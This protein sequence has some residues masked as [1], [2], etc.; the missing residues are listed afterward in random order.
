M[1]SRCAVY[2]LRRYFDDPRYEGFGPVIR[3]SMP[4][5]YPDH[6]TTRNWRIR[7]IS[8][9]WEPVAVA[10]RVRKDNDYPC[11][12]NCP[13]FSRRAVDALRDYL[14]P[15]GEILPLKSAVGEYYA[16]NT[17]TI[18]DSLDVKKSRVRWSVEPITAYR[19]EHFKFFPDKLA[20]HT[21]FLIPEMP[22]DPLVTSEFVARAHL[23]GLNG[24]HFVKVW[25]LPENVLWWDL[26][27]QEARIHKQ[28]GLRTGQTIKGNT[29]MVQLFLG[30]QVA[31]P[32]ERKAVETVMNDI[33]VVLYSKTTD[34]TLIG[35][36]EGHDYGVPGECR[37]FI[38]C[39]DA[40]A[41][42]EKLKPW[43]NQLKW[44]SANTVQQRTSMESPNG[45]R[46]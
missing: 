17:T 26:Q 19:V 21:I 2:L 18:A 32:A 9:T 15:N 5:F 25:P 3:G 31:T 39:P 6:R 40:D 13:A 12:V 10:G 8:K 16:Y 41:L 46:G 11:V 4:K 30:G 29:I 22:S 14:E 23:K 27:K 20:N 38:S 44:P 1:N 34:S 37:L 35:N 42:A 7:Q 45:F 33:D 43:L 36:L 28:N 24:M